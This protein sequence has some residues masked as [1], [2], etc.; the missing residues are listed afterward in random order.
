MKHADGLTVAVTGASGYL[1]TR[2]IRTLCSDERI[3]RVLGFDLGPPQFKSDKFIFDV[4]DVRDRRLSSRL[5]DVDVIVHLAF[6]MD[7]NRDEAVMRDINVNGSQNVFI[8]AAD[9]G[10]GKIV[11]S[12]SA[13]VYGA[14]P[15]NDVPLTEESPLRANL[16]FSYAAHK[17]EVEYVVK[18]FRAEHP[19]VIFT[20]LRPAIVFGAGVD[21]AWSHF[22]EAPLLFGVKGHSPPWQCVHEDDVASGAAFAIFNDLNGAYNLAPRGWL[23]NDEA[24]ELIGRSRAELSESTAFSVMDRLWRARPCGPPGR[25]PALRHAPLG[26]V[27]RQVNQGRFHLRALERRHSDRSAVSHS[28]LRPHRK[29]P[30]PQDV[31]EASHDPG[32]GRPAG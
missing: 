9:A 21:N 32:G 5:S 30:F 15:D 29:V 26:T 25:D 4:V 8:A 1:G 6:V 24:A 28:S 23:E 27:G 22:M 20:L 31:V 7:P 13:T 16:D 2:L 11:Y 10:V 14:H 12:S 18:E 17:L 19:S 3:D